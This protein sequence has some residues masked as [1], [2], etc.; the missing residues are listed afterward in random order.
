M[1]FLTDVAKNFG[2]TVQ[3]KE[4][5]SPVAEMIG[6]K[7]GKRG[8]KTNE[9]LL[10][11]YAGYVYRAIEVKATNVAREELYTE[12]LINGQWQR[13]THAGFNA[14]LNGTADSPSQTWMRI[15]STTYKQIFGEAFWYV[16]V[17]ESSRKPYDRLL[18]YPNRVKVIADSNGKVV[19][20][21]YQ[22]GTG[23]EMPLE[24]DE[25]LHFKYFNPNNH[26][27]GFSPLQAA[28][29]Y[30]DAERNTVEYVANFI[31]N[32]ATPSGIILLPADTA[33][34]QF[35][36]FEQNWKQRFSGINNVG[37][38]A[39]LQAS[40]V[41][42]KQISST[43][44]DMQ[45][46]EL[47]TMSR[48]DIL[49]VLGM[50]KHMI[51][52][53]DEG[54]MGRA[55]AETH[56]YIFAKRVLEPEL[57][58]DANTFNDAFRRYFPAEANTWR[59]GFD[60]PVPEDKQYKLSVVDAGTTLMTLNERRSMLGLPP[61]NGGDTLT[62]DDGSV[63]NVKTLGKIKIKK[64]I[65]RE[66]TYEQKESYRLSIQDKQTAYERRYKKVVKEFIDEQ[67]EQVLGDLLGEQAKGLSK[68]MTDG[69]LDPTK[70]GEKLV[71]MSLGT[72]LTMIEEQ[73]NLAIK[74]AGGTEK[75]VVTPQ[76][77]AYVENSIGR[78]ALEF[79]QDIIAS[80]GKA[81]AEGL[82]ND[83]SLMQIGERIQ[84]QYKDIG[85]YKMN[86]LVRTETLKGSNEATQFGYGQLGI[87]E[88]E[89]FNNPGACD[90]CSEVQ[91]M[92]KQ[93]L[94]DVFLAKGESLTD[95]EGNE[96]VYDYED[97]EHPPL[98]PNC[99]C[100]LLPVRD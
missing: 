40:G 31:E 22:I 93:G 36:Q 68:A 49:G 42:F 76:V 28:G 66:K 86:R 4:L 47:K 53:A 82:R 8:N 9:Q 97:V 58:D 95:R 7:R 50:S 32:N 33:D 43:L 44:K 79:N 70:Q 81:V 21:T 35:R 52:I 88:K 78:A 55:T 65:T 85:G 100:V 15:G 56:E 67:K 17:L 6:G 39:I 91:G 61:V 87:S 11:D 12:Q 34:A 54:G 25:V 99:R 69:N 20:Y 18:L 26:L 19:G 3:H 80:I 89:W 74:F 23:N 73:G 48:D 46:S 84:A 14:L 10:S 92:G 71:R 64:I 96:R 37:K 2:N 24:V 13:K 29:L 27:R 62:G 94:G 75:F 59:I 77:K 1:G 38:T 41:D 72:L 16:N 57:S 5:G 45:L 60:D 30:V 83:E 63:L 90:F 98:H 51:G